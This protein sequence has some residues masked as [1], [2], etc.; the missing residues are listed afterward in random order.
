MEMYD[1]I[2]RFFQE[3]GPFMYPV[4]IVAGLASFLSFV[5]SVVTCSIMS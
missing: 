4:P 1:T 2:V 3:G 5:L